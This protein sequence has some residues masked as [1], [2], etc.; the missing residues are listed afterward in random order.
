MH[1]VG[2]AVHHGFE[3]DGHLLLDLLRGNARPLGDDLDVVVGDVGIRFH[4]KL[5]ERDRAP[6]Q[7]QNCRCQDE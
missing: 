3:R 6:G 1:H 4:G 5:M 2:N 7:Q